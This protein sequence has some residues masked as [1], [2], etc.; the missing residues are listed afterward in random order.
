MRTLLSLKAFRLRPLAGLAVLLLLVTT[1]C[2]YNDHRSFGATEK[3]VHS[4]INRV[5]KIIGTPFIAIVDGIISPVTAACDQ[6]RSEEPYHPDH[7]YLS[8][9]GSRV[10][11]RSDMGDGYIWLASVPSI[12]L[13]TVWLIITGPIDLVTVLVSDD[14]HSEG[15]PTDH[16]HTHE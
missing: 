8:Y 1:G 16:T 9:A 12:I 10:V 2:R 13:E 7:R 15:P 11:A 14:T 4:D 3:W 6:W 5:P